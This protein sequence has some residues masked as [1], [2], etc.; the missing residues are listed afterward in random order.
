MKIESIEVRHYR[1]PLDPPFPRIV[2]S[3]PADGVRLDD[4]RR[5]RGW[6]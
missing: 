3:S 5:A 6:V 1:L 4:R 2:G